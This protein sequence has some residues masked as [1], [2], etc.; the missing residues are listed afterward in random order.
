[1]LLI[2]LITYYLY[3]F[4]IASWFAFT[5]H[6][7]SRNQTICASALCCYLSGSHEKHENR[8]KTTGNKCFVLPIFLSFSVFIPNVREMHL[9]SYIEFFHQ[10][11]H[12][13]FSS[14]NFIHKSARDERQLFKSRIYILNRR[15]KQ[16]STKSRRIWKAIN[17]TISLCCIEPQGFQVWST[18]DFLRILYGTMKNKM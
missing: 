11:R 14:W 4:K 18:E 17:W 1:M 8:M 9:I 7:S 2:I 5:F 3:R 6:I 10:A 13:S 16:G 12:F 15:Y